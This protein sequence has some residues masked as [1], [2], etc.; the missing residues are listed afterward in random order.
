MSF[1]C[2]MCWDIKITHKHD[3]TVWS[4][5]VRRGL[6]QKGELVQCDARFKIWTCECNTAFYEHFWTSVSD[7]SY[8][9]TF[10]SWMFASWETALHCW[11]TW[12]WWY[13]FQGLQGRGWWNAWWCDHSCTMSWKQRICD[14]SSCWGGLWGMWPRSASWFGWR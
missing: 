14:Y 13:L 5:A 1:K 12:W 11:R 9:Q 3:Y 2:L 8:L 10:V 4:G 7:C 6:R